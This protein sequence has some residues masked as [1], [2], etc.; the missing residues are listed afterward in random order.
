MVFERHAAQQESFG[1]QLL[2]FVIVGAVDQ[3]EAHDVL[4]V[5]CGIDAPLSRFVPP[6]IFARA[7]RLSISLDGETSPA[8]PE[9][10]HAR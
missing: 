7:M 3:R 10:F 9:S 1:A 2:E 8:R 6:G 5:N 4:G